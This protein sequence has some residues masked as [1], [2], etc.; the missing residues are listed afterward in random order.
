MTELKGELKI[1]LENIGGFLGRSQDFEIKEKGTI[2][3]GRRLRGINRLK[4]PNAVGKSSFVYGLQTL[5]LDDKELENRRHFLNVFGTDGRVELKTKDKEIVRRIRAGKEKL[6]A[7]GTQI[8][9]EGDKANIFAFATEDNPLIAM[10]KRNEPLR[11]ELLKFSGAL[12]YESL[13]GVLEDKRREY[14]REV[15]KYRDELSKLKT[16]Y[17][18]KDQL[19]K[20]IDQLEEKRR[21]LPELPREKEEREAEL[22]AK[23]EAKTEEKIRIAKLIEAKKEEVKRTEAKIEELRQSADRLM[24]EVRDFREKHVDIERELEQLSQR[25]QELAVKLEDLKQRQNIKQA[26]LRDTNTNMMRYTS[27]GQDYCFS[28]GQSITPQRLKKRLGDLNR[29]IKELGDDIAKITAEKDSAINEYSELLREKTKV[30]TELEREVQRKEQTIRQENSALDRA[31]RDIEKLEPDMEKISRELSNLQKDLDER[32][33]SIMEQRAQIDTELGRLD[34]RVKSIEKQVKDMG[35]VQ[36]KIDDI[37]TKV[38]FFKDAEL[39]AEKAAHELRTVVKETFDK[40]IIEILRV[41]EFK[42]FQ[43]IYL[44]D[45]FNI[46]INR[47]KK[48]RVEPDTIHSLSRSEKET[49]A[50]MM[51]LAGKEEYLPDFPFF[52]ADETTF[53]DQTRFNRLVDY[54]SEKVPYTIVTE[55]V[56]MEQQ[57]N[58][59]MEYQ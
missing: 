45:N 8:Y 52:V 3:E 46:R 13:K 5:V 40:R 34:E 35:D 56:P 47:Q 6:T 39:H 27:Y 19:K 18:A 51:M 33:K 17:H 53:Y 57:E 55:L 43:K 23:V 20:N 42:E 2:Y 1:V 14:E 11:A 28:C 15:Q 16:L 12:E 58:L 21:R 50:M 59:T 32:A 30:E 29:D 25:R 31:K 7:G 48:G 44:D 22:R 4:S 49:V 10:V 9:P 41:L 36:T 24:E 37:L 38:Q 26:E 54:I